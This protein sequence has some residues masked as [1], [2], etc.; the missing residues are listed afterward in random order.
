DEIDAVEVLRHQEVQPPV[1]LVTEVEDAEHV[2][3]IHPRGRECLGPEARDPLLALGV[4]GVVGLA[5]HLHRATASE[6]HILRPAA[7]AHRTGAE[8]PAYAVAAAEHL[9]DE[10]RARRRLPTRRDLV[11]HDSRRRAGWM[12]AS[13]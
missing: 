2:R 8:Q 13:P 7:P 3:V 12:P 9:A 5:D 1:G 4:R 6:L 10:A 11:I